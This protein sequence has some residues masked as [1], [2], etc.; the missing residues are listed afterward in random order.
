M[1]FER[2]AAKLVAATD[3]VRVVGSDGAVRI[4]G[5]LRLTEIAD[6]SGHAFCDCAKEPYFSIFWGNFGVGFRL[7]FRVKVFNALMFKEL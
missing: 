7:D 6:F 3:K 2:I 1:S 4:T 5:S